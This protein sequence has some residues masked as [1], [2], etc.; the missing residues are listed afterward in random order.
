LKQIKIT[1]VV[2]IL[3]NF[4]HVFS[5]EKYN[6]I[7]NHFFIEDLVMVTD[8]KGNFFTFLNNEISLSYGITN[9][10][11]LGVFH[12][13]DKKTFKET[14]NMFLKDENLFGIKGSFSFMP[15]LGEEIN[16]HLTRWDFSLSANL[17]YNRVIYTIVRFS[18][19]K[20]YQHW[21]NYYRFNAKYYLSPKVFLSGSIGVLNTNR[22][23][24][25]VGI[26]L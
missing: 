7:R 19:V 24:I 4:T 16:K 17:S 20:D 22:F 8:T 21:E 2:I 25:G 1:L 26:K 13:L 23:F 6:K 14:D 9:W 11:S 10:L 12:E 18:D 3:L 15:L 5:Q